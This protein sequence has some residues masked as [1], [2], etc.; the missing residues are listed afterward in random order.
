MSGNS[1]APAMMEKLREKFGDSVTSGELYAFD[2]KALFAARK[3]ALTKKAHGVFSLVGEV[4]QKIKQKSKAEIEAER[5]QTAEEIESRFDALELLADAIVDGNIRSLT[6]SGAA[7]VGKSYMLERKLNEALADDSINQVTQV[8]GTISAIGLYMTLWENN[9]DGDIVVLDDIDSI[10]GDEEAMNLLKG[11]LDTNGRRVISWIKDSRFLKDQ[12]IPNSFEYKGR[13]V[14]LTNVDLQNV[15]DKGG[16]MAPH[17]GALMSRSVYLDL[18]IHTPEQILI[19]IRQVLKTSDMGLG[20]SAAQTQLILD[21]MEAN[22]NNLRAISLRT[23]IQCAGFT[24]VTKD[25]QLLAR[26]TLLRT[27]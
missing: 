10:Y 5:K 18:G 23:V 14:F 21:W 2:P 25:W 7:G 26:N 11:A 8:K 9:N 12:D 6:V 1:I 4:Q 24:K 20:L 3:G 19:R 17:M 13:I 16:R 15:A 27:R 22:M